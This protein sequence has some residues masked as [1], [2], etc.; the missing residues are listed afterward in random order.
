MTYCYD[1]QNQRG[2]ERS[3]TRMCQHKSD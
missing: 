3:V 2:G 1:Y